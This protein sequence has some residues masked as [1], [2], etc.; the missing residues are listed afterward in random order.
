MN[1][2]NE[3]RK[4][5]GISLKDLSQQTKINYHTLRSYEYGYRDIKK[6]QLETALKISKVLKIRIEDLVDDQRKE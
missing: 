6:M 3:Y 1:R 4:N 5:A 2:I